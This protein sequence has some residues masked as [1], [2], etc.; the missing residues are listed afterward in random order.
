VK[1]TKQ[2]LKDL[3][4]EELTKDEEKKKEELEKDLEKLKH[5]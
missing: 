5:K 4:K 1:L 3:I 2:T